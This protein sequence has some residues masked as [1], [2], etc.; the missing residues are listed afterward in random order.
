ML[1]AGLAL[2]MQK[3]GLFAAFSRGLVSWLAKAR[4][5]YLSLP[6]ASRWIWTLLAF[7]WV[8]GMSYWDEMRT[9]WQTSWFENLAAGKRQSFK[10]YLSVGLWWST[11]MHLCLLGFLVVTVRWW[12]GGRPARYDLGANDTSNTFWK[13]RRFFVALTLLCVLAAC[14]RV[15]RLDLS[16]WGDEGW[17]VAPYVYGKHVPVNPD[18]PQGPLMHKPVDWLNTA[19]DDRTGGNHYLFSLVQRATLTLWRWTR[20][21]PSDAFDESI[22]RLPPL[23][24]GLGSIALLALWLRWL[25]RPGAGLASA[26]LLA[27]H[28]WHLRYSTEARG[29]SMMLFFLI[30]ALWLACVALKTGRWRWWLAFGAAEFLC[31]YSW[32]GVLYPLSLANLVLLLWMI[33][34]RLSSASTS[35]AETATASRSTS[36][37]RWLVASLI[38]AGWFINLVYPCLLQVKDA[39]Q[40]LVQ[41]SGRPMGR[42]WFHN[43]ISGVFVGTPWHVEDERNP[44]EEVL[45]KHLQTR[46]VLTG[47][48]LLGTLSLLIVGAVALGL[49]SRWLAALQFALFSGGPVGALTFSWLIH[50]EWISWYSFFMILPLAICGGHGIAFLIQRFLP[51]P[52]TL[53]N[54]S[55]PQATRPLRVRL[56]CVL[57]AILLPSAQAAVMLPSSRLMLTQAYEDHRGAFDLTRGRHEPLHHCGSSNIH[58]LYLWRYISLYDPRGDTHVRKM[59]E[60]RQRVAEVE[61]TGAELYMIVGHQRLARKLNPTLLGIIENPAHFDYLGTLWAVEELHSLHCYRFRRGSFPVSAPGP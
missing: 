37:W 28:P 55:Q 32:K 47:L 4:D 17:A 7:L 57:L 53:L 13:P 12:A 23:V 29:Y 44:T 5:A 58:T 41:L 45:E 30:L 11:L 33:R 50:A 19:F 61:K 38:A 51:V 9:P 59:D 42:I 36:I 24:A 52:Q 25:G 43:T 26:L 56:A 27:A 39:K 6:A 49:Q 35:A 3:S 1:P 46:P 21:L 54:A 31:M 16:Y 60:F 14:V 18:Q 40:Q 8:A 10:N 20:N 22:S 48:G 34:G 2:F 15:P